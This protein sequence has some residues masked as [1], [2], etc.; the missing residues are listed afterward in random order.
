MIDDFGTRGH[1]WQQR[2]KWSISEWF[3]SNL[4]SF[5]VAVCVSI[6]GHFQG[7]VL[8]TWE[9]GDSAWCFATGDK[10]AAV[11]SSDIWWFHNFFVPF[12]RVNSNP[13]QSAKCRTN[14]RNYANIFREELLRD[15]Y[16]VFFFNLCK[17]FFP[18]V[19]LDALVCD[20]VWWK[21]NLVPTWRWMI[22]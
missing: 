6:L 18:A 20:R 9:H 3:Q 11:V 13:V 4:V 15:Q 16:A 17:F 2:W 8:K 19:V 12:V 1:L 5:V 14:V 10:V 22:L 7:L 21:H